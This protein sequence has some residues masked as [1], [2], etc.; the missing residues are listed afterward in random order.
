MD[1]SSIAAFNTCT[2]AA[3]Q[4]ETLRSLSAKTQ[5]CMGLAPLFALGPRTRNFPLMGLAWIVL[6]TNGSS[7]GY[8]GNLLTIS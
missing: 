4:P 2:T 1:N 7:E 3:F 6:Q 8:K 5:K